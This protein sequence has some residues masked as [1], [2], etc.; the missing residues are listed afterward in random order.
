MADGLRCG[1]LPR[2]PERPF[3]PRTD[4]PPEPPE[5]SPPPSPSGRCPRST[6][7]TWAITR[8]ETRGWPPWPLLCASFPR[9]SRRFSTRTRSPN[10]G[11]ATL[12]APPTANV[13]AVLETLTVNDNQITD[14]GCAAFAAALCS[15]S[16]PALKMLR[17]P[18]KTLQAS[19]R[20]KRVSN[21]SSIEKLLPLRE[22]GLRHVR[23][24]LRQQGAAGQ[25]YDSRM[26]S[27]A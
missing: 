22:P 2:A 25:Q 12:L 19:T 8:L 26:N 11:L 16:L 24:R 21:R 15:G 20:K 9:S 23:V 3:G 5:R 27:I 13:L 1:G 6:T 7:L 14:E 18:G 4:Q 17:L 10:L